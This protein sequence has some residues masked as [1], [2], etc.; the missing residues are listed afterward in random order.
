MKIDIMLGSISRYISTSI[1]EY[2]ELLDLIA[3]TMYD[4]NAYYA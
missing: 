4:T 2:M 3:L 1:W